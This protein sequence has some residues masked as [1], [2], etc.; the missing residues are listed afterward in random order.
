MSVF[1]VALFAQ[2]FSDDDLFGG[3]SDLD[4]FDDADSFFFDDGIE[5]FYVS[6]TPF[7][8]T[9]TA[10]TTSSYSSSSLIVSPS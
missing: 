4:L 9:E 8:G 5:E 1:A 2:D 6:E 7:T 3:S 10:P